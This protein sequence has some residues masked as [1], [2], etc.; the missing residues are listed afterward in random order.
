MEYNPGN[1]SR[2]VDSAD[3]LSSLP[4]YILHQILSLL[5][6]KSAVQT[7]VLS[8]S[9]RCRW[10]YVPVIDLLLP[11]CAD[12]LSFRTYVDK[13][14]SLR[15]PVALTKISYED[16][17]DALEQDNGLF[18]KIMKYAAS[19]D[20]QHLDILLFRDSYWSY[21][22]FCDVLDLLSGSN[23]NTL[24]AVNVCLDGRFKS[25]HFPL[26]T[27][28]ELV[29]CMFIP[30]DPAERF[31][32]FSNLPCLKTLVL[33]TCI[34]YCEDVVRISGQQLQ[35]LKLDHVDACKMEISA[36]N[37]KSFT[38]WNAWK[39][40]AFSELT[41]P[42]LDHFDIGVIDRKE[43]FKTDKKDWVFLFQGLHNVKSLTLNDR[44]IEALVDISEFLEEQASPFKRLEKLIIQCNNKPHKVVNSDNIPYKVVNYFFKGSLATN[45]SI[46]VLVEEEE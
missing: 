44:I 22:N 28:L 24:Q 34:S 16:R 35:T 23:L 30:R 3:R 15:Y 7:S 41:L 33:D 1:M 42:S 11:S 8:R 10:K 17:V 19:H 32:P 37:L 6:T 25:L 5:D 36:P 4:D 14:L 29:D 20:I 12:E 39:E 26:M 45:P 38:L 46:K 2:G 9:W 27:T 40:F 18:V 31:E 21:K 43:F 13:V